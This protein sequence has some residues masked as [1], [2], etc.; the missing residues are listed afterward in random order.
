MKIFPRDIVRILNVHGELVNME[1]AKEEYIKVALANWY[2][3]G[4]LISR[5]TDTTLAIDIGSI[6]TL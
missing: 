1:R 6:T 5:I 3:A 4:W 2:A